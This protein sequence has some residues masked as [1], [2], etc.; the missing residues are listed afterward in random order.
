MAGSNWAGRSTAHS[1]YGSALTSIL[2]RTAREWS[3]G[4]GVTMQSTRFLSHWQRSVTQTENISGR[5]H[6]RVSEQTISHSLAAFP[7]INSQ[8]KRTRGGPSAWKRSHNTRVSLAG[9]DLGGWES[10]RSAASSS[11]PA[12]VAFVTTKRRALDRATAST[13]FQ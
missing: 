12:S 2:S 8:G 10:T 4:A 3:G 5:A 1:E 7:S 6:A 11:Y 13:S 9:I